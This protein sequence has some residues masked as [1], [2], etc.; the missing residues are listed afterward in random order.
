MNGATIDSVVDGIEPEDFFSSQARIASQLQHFSS[1]LKTSLEGITLETTREEYRHTWR[2]FRKRLDELYIQIHETYFEKSQF[3]NFFRVI[4]RRTGYELSDFDF[5]IDRLSLIYT[6][7]TK[8]TVPGE[9]FVINR[10][11]ERS[12]GILS[13]IQKVAAGRSVYD[14]LGGTAIIGHR[15]V[16]Q[17]NFEGLYKSEDINNLRK[18]ITDNAD[19]LGFEDDVFTNLMGTDDFN[20]LFSNFMSLYREKFEPMNRDAVRAFMRFQ[21]EHLRGH[22]VPI[23]PQDYVYRHTLFE[24]SSQRFVDSNIIRE[25]GEYEGDFMSRVLV[26]PRNEPADRFFEEVKSEAGGEFYDRKNFKQR[27]YKAIFYE[28]EDEYF[29]L[30]KPLA[31]RGVVVVHSGK[32]NVYKDVSDFKEA[33]RVFVDVFMKHKLET[34]LDGERYPEIGEPELSPLSYLYIEGEIPGAYIIEP[35]TTEHTKSDREGFL[36][37]F[38]F[39]NEERP[40]LSMSGYVPEF[41]GKDFSK[42]PKSNEYQS[43]HLRLDNRVELMGETEFQRWNNE[44]GEASH[45]VYEK[46]SDKKQIIKI[47][48]QVYDIKSERTPLPKDMKER[49][50]GRKKKRMKHYLT[51][52]FDNIILW[53]RET[54]LERIKKI[55]SE[56]NE[57]YMRDSWFNIINF[58]KFRYHFERYRKLIRQA[59]NDILDMPINY[60]RN[61]GIN[62]FYEDEEGYV[63]IRNAIEMGRLIVRKG[64]YLDGEDPKEEEQKA[65][66]R[67]KR[68][69]NGIYTLGL[70][71]IAEEN[72]STEDIARNVYGVGILRYASQ[73]RGNLEFD[74]VTFNDDQE[75]RS[76][77]VSLQDLVEQFDTERIKTKVKKFRKQISDLAREDFNGKPE[78]WKILEQTAAYVNEVCGRQLSLTDFG[79]PPRRG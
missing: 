63:H 3:D 65:K 41:L 37:D 16:P 49:Q 18:V 58:E 20:E 23:Y 27:P 30:V 67:F 72:L 38:K 77:T 66:K 10:F 9:S 44:Y 53:V 36:D 19:A 15:D 25:R 28:T 33:C 76:M 51:Q 64:I 74:D 52:F 2:E 32:K 4:L 78:Y 21:Q 35:L 59:R 57:D 34:E 26:F 75:I 24:M 40:V 39:L 22:V 47:R 69:A 54:H 14:L 79:A 8:K 5:D 42:R 55:S 45:R 73:F 46:T 31:K 50:L 43:M 11:F 60:L 6:N 17:F 12:K 62:V 48:D 68:C 7:Q 29:C 56:V 61:Q 13:T 1:A 71:E 70:L